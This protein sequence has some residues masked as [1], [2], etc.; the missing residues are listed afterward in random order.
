MATGS[1]IN[2]LSDLRGT[3]DYSAVVLI[4]LTSV[5]APSSKQRSL[6]V[7]PQNVLVRI[8]LVPQ[9]FAKQPGLSSVFG[10]LLVPENHPNSTTST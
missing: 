7:V 3:P 5:F 2:G 4:S 1:D 9:A 10:S 8:L 6:A